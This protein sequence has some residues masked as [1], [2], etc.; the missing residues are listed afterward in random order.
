MLVLVAREV[1]GDAEELLALVRADIA[2]ALPELTADPRLRELLAATVRDTILSALTVFGAGTPISSVHP[3]E[4]GIRLAR[5]LAQR[6]VSIAV[7]L[8]AYR[9][10]Q[11]RVQQELITRIA[12]RKASAEEVAEAARDLSS[13]AF[14]FVDLVAEEVVAAYQAERDDWMRRR[15]AA[16]LAKITAVLRAPGGDLGDAES[17]LGYELAR[18]GHLAAVFWSETDAASRLAALE[19]RM[20]KLAGAVG[21]LRP[22]LV[23]APDAATLWAWF[24]VGAG[25]EPA[26][27]AATTAVT[28]ELAEL[29]E[30]YAALGDPA[31]G[32]DGFRRSHQQARQAQVLALAADPG[33][34]PRV[35][36]PAVL[37]PLV[38]LA[39]EPGAAAGWVRSV[40]GQLAADD[41]AHARL[42]ET[43]WAYL[44]SGSSLATAA[45]ELHLHKNTIQYRL[46]KAEEARGRP[47]ADG[48]LDVEVALLACRL[49]G[50]AVLYQPPATTGAT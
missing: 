32:V 27:A 21:A 30:V 31:P 19:R 39:L 3:P 37:G 38:L 8:R 50:T 18:A 10:G 42:R 5:R 40:L 49:L 11:A 44:S 28:A 9:L 26:S 36:A 41:E 33:A 24:P 45:A 16:R 25:A 13:T 14:G 17:A 22:P 46:R 12:A 2:A 43:L 4:A 34:R 48:R 7:M 47:L 6:N 15:N 23:V 1:A 29:G 35:T 20:P